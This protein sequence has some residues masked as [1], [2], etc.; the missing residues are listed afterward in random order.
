MFR[1]VQLES[2]QNLLVEKALSPE[3]DYE[4]EYDMRYC[5]SQ[6]IKNY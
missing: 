6:D 5:Q 2:L 4:A 3:C 1:L